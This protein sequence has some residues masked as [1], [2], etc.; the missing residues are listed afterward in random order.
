[1][2]AV[3]YFILFIIIILRTN[4]SSAYLFTPTRAY[5][6]PY[7]PLRL[8]KTNSNIYKYVCIYIYI[9]KYI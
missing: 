3:C 4:F 9:N 1:M 7:P 5:E 2:H 6:Y 8:P